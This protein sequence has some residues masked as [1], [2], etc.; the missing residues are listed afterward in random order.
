MSKT[1]RHSATIL[2]PSVRV[3][4][5]EAVKAE[6][7][8]RAG[9]YTALPGEGGWVA[10]DGTVHIQPVV[11]VKVWHN[12]D[13]VIRRF[14]VESIGILQSYGEQSVMYETSTSGVE[15]SAGVVE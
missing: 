3:S 5:L 6:A 13:W 9:G 14:V 1:L 10:P 15:T 7:L 8:G 12:D 2:V 4:A 11:A